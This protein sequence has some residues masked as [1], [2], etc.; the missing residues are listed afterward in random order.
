[1]TGLMIT[2]GAITVIACLMLA[3]VASVYTTPFI[4]VSFLALSA[5]AGYVAAL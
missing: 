3:A 2:L 1:M 5:V 4:A